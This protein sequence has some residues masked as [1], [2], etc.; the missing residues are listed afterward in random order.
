MHQNIITKGAVK[1]DASLIIDLINTTLIVFL[2]RKIHKDQET[3]NQVI[4]KLDTVA[5]NP[6]KGRKMPRIKKK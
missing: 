5:K 4:E 3:L 6:M 1:M 2:A